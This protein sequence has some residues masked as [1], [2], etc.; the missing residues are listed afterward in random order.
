MVYTLVAFKYDS[1]SPEQMC[2]YGVCILLLQAAKYGLTR[3]EIEFQ[4]RSII[5]DRD[6]VKQ[7]GWDDVKQMII[8]DVYEANRSF[9]RSLLPKSSI[10]VL[11]IND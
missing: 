7:L 10:R 2:D 8:G 3:N 9:L 5:M 11:W 4:M 6:Y 1:Q